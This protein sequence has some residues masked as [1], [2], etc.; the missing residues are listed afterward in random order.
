MLTLRTGYDK[1]EDNLYSWIIYFD[2][3]YLWN[4]L[5]STL[6]I[7]NS[8]GLYEILLDIRTSTYQICI[9]DEKLIRTTT[10]NKYIYNWT[11]D[12]LLVVK[13]MFRHGPDFHFEISGYSI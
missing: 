10:F 2:K 13:Y 3:V 7:S 11:L 8:K 9:I 4:S 5:Q 6:V 1:L 12:V